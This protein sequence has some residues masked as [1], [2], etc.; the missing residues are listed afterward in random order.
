MDRRA[1][2]QGSVAGSLA[3]VASMLTGCR[4]RQVAHVVDDSQSDMVGSHAAGAETYNRLVAESVA[5]L[6][7]SQ[8]Q[9]FDL[10]FTGYG[11]EGP[12][13]ICFVGIE[14]KSEEEMG[15]FKEQLYQEIDTSISTSGNF[16]PISR[17]Y[18]EQ[19]LQQCHLRP[20]QLLTPD[21]QRAFVA[22]MEQVGQPFDYL[23]YA[24]LTSGTTINNKD[25]QRDYLL[26]LELV[27][28]HDGTYAK[29]S[30]KVRKGYH[31]SYLGKWRIYNPFSVER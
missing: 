19:G 13:R 23:L 14:N 5:R 6:L 11:N 31:R 25:K 10:E 16:R 30:A 2:V 3:A 12:R 17:R 22:A 15:G 27:N 7:S 28:I 18:V 21:G 8:D 4:G 29:D 26:T 9:A 24:T 20:E 1:F